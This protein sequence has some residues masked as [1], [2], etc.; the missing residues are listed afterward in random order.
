MKRPSGKLGYNPILRFVETN[1]NPADLATRGSSAQDFN[2]CELWWH[3]PKW[4]EDNEEAWPTWNIPEVTKEI[5]ERMESETKS[6]KTFYETT[7][8]AGEGVHGGKAEVKKEP[9][10]FAVDDKKYSSLLRLLRIT[11]WLLRFITK[12]RKEKSQTRETESFRNQTRKDVMDQVNPK[13]QLP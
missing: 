9:T 6:Q 12:V 2:K 13:G 7:K 3:G 4:L 5:L 8:L 10:P 11:A 1:K